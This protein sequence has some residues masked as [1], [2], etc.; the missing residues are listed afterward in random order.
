ME[1][2]G[3]EPQATPPYVSY[4]TLANFLRGLSSAAIPSRIDKSVMTSMSGGVQVQVMQ[5][6]KYL[7]LIQPNGTPT[8]KLP[9]LVKSEGAEHQRILREVLVA[10]YPFLSDESIRLE[11]ATM[12]Q[13][14]EAFKPLASGDTA[15]KCLTFFIPAAKAAG[16]QLS[17]YIREPGKR[18]SNGRQRARPKSATP[19]T[20]TENPEVNSHIDKTPGTMGWHELLLSKFPSFDPSWP[21][22]VK[23]KWFASFEQLMQS[24]AQKK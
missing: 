23:T 8:E 1:K 6:L 18:S 10:A 5:A 14:E 13:L 22:D 3:Q 12:H 24:G 17:A 11:N 4:K 21:D 20:A 16:I 7:K 19:R 9:A 15:R 2:S